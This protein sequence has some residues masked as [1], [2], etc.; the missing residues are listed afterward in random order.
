M[1]TS[2][3]LICAKIVANVVTTTTTSNTMMVI[4]G[5]VLASII[6]MDGVDR[7]DRLATSES[8]ANPAVWSV[9]QLLLDHPSGSCGVSALVAQSKL[10][11]YKLVFSSRHLSAD[12]VLNFQSPP[13]T[14]RL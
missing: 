8:R 5:R 3:S 14:C 11:L 6:R 12:L 7:T 13:S 4:G 1:P 2:F 10:S 9:W